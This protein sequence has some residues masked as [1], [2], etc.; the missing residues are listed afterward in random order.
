MSETYRIFGAEPSPYSV[1]VRSYMRY[2]GIPHKWVP[3][4]TDVMEEYQRYARLPLIPCLVAPDN[5]AMQDSTPIIEAL[6]AQFPDPAILTGDPAADFISALLEEYG[7]EWG[8]K[9]MFHYRWTYEEDQKATAKWIA[10]ETVADGNEEMRDGIEGMIMGRMPGRLWFVG[11]SEQTRDQIEGSFK[12]LL[13]RLEDHLRNR[14]YIFGGRPAMADFGIWPQLY[15]T[16]IDPTPRKVMLSG[17]PA[18]LEYVDRML[19]PEAI[20][21]FEALDDLMPTLGP[22][23]EDEVGGLFL[24]WSDSNARALAAEEESFAVALQGSDFSQKPQKYHARSLGALRAKYD[25]V[26]DKSSLDPILERTGCLQW[27]KTKD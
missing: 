22:L 10:A 1:K 14:E 13:Q 11:S 3:R 12:R 25:A 20:G 16:S 24:P 9:H 7:D 19:F 18:V 17:F 23:L 26:S 21:E 15:Q 5:T 27:L 6:E 8:N 2:K 4:T